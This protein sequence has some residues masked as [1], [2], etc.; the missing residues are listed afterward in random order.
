MKRENEKDTILKEFQEA[1]QLQKFF[2]QYFIDMDQ[3]ISGNAYVH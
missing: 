1:F 2:R 3:Y